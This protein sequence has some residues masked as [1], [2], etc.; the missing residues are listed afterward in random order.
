M[1]AAAFQADPA[2]RVLIVDDDASVCETMSE[3]LEEAGLAVHCA[4]TDREAYALLGARRGYVALVVDVNLG[5]GTTGFDVARFGRQLKAELPV[6]YISGQAS[7]ASFQAFGVP[8]SSLLEKPFSPQE[9]VRAVQ[10]VIGDNE[11]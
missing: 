3:A 4:Q 10:A 7:R 6:I 1:A 9:L 11:R 2:E 5:V 8:G